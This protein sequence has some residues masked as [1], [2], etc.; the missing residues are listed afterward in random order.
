MSFDSKACELE[1]NNNNLIL[2]RGQSILMIT[3]EHVQTLQ[4]MQDQADFT[5]YL[6]TKAL[7]NR[8]ARRVYQSWTRKDR[9]LTA[10][11]FNEFKS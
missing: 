11:I 1:W 4:T 3:P 8:E 2:R 10:K 9:D 7:V 6:T 5:D